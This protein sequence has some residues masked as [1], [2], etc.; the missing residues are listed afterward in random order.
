MNT[1]VCLSSDGKIRSFKF[2]HTKIN[3]LFE[4]DY[5]FCASFPDEK[6]VALSSLD[7]TG[8]EFNPFSKNRELFEEDVYGDI[9]L[10]G[11][12]DHSEACDVDLDFLQRLEC[13]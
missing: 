1:V 5:H 2:D 7:P 12:D 3:L 13:D 4:S 11:N 8:K 9:Y 10:F 6:I